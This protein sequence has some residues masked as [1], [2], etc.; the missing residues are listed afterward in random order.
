MNCEIAH[1]RIVTAAYGELAD[2]QAHELERHLAGCPDCGKEREQ[3]LALKV[4]AGCV[5]GGGAGGEPGGAL[6]AEVGRG[7][8]CAAAAALV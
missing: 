8:G 2:E 4:L 5:S 6:A 1:E 3:L 7:A